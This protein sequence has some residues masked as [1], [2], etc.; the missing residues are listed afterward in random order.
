MMER[1]L[2]VLPTYNEKENLENMV[3]ELKK[4]PYEIHLLIVDDNS[5]DGTGK[6]ADSLAADDPLIHV[7]HREG[8]LGLG[9]AYIK[10]F[11]WALKNTDIQYIMEMDCDFSHNP[12]YIPS[13]V[14]PVVR[15]EADLVIGSRYI[16]GVNVVNWPLKRLLLS[17]FAS[18]YTRIISG[19]PVKDSTGGFKCFRRKVLETIDLS[20]IKSDGYSFQIEMNFYCWRK[21]FSIKEVPIV[22]VDRYAGQSKMSKK[23]VYEA[24][25]LV[26]RLRFL[27]LFNKV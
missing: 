1:I 12:E 19:L 24:I 10:G 2:I 23:I 21:K 16:K 17:Y 14:E 27:R 5:P 15:G 4:N 3:R 11:Q 22:F 25:W 26:W 13:L 6:I 9:S 7:I 8:K 20:H 18:I